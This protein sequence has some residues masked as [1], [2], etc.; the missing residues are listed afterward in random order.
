MKE[1]DDKRKALVEE[2][3]KLEDHQTVLNKQV[4]ALDRLVSKVRYLYYE[5]KCTDDIYLIL[6]S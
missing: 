4:E 1:I 3:S 2:K 5:T 6:I